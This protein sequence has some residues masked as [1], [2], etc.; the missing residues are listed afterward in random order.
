MICKYKI[1][2]LQVLELVREYPFFCKM[3]YAFRDATYLYFVLGKLF[4][5]ISL[6]IAQ[7]TSI[8]SIFQLDY[9]PGGDL[10]EYLRFVDGFIPP[11]LVRTWAAEL[12]ITLETLHNL[13]ILFRDL[14]LEN[15][16]LDAKGHTVLCDFNI[17]TKLTGPKFTT[18][19]VCGT[20][21]YMAPGNDPLEF[22]NTFCTFILIRKFHYLLQKSYH[23]HRKITERVIVLISI[24]GLWAL[25][26]MNWQRVKH[27]LMYPI[28]SQINRKSLKY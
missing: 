3:H 28:P 11:E 9:M 19:E 4:Y 27:H 13:K 24:G 25:L 20:Y 7:F 15:I 17:S 12:V 18:H 6:V 8:F 5:F 21:S 1:Y 10:F 16:L 23:S 2:F 26:C 14:K 22:R